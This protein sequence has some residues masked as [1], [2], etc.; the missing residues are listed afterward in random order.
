[1]KFRVVERDGRS[2][3]RI[4]QISDPFTSKNCGKLDCLVCQTGG[5]GYCRSTSVT[6][7]IKCLE[8][9]ED[10]QSCESVYE[11][12]TSRNCY[13]R[14]KEHYSELNSKLQSSAL[15]RHSR[16]KHDSRNLEYQ[17]NV[18]GVYKNDAMLRQIME[19]V[20]IANSSNISLLNSK[21][22][23]NNYQLADINLGGSVKRV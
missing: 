10:P 21:Q 18:T 16:D 15:W 20:R 9:S 1:M 5:K 4:L 19:S 11:G 12:E 8:C 17:M 22:E 3:K 23:W 14:G 7:N 2:I 13:T 6:Y